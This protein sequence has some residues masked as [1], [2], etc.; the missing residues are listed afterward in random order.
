MHQILL[1]RRGGG[2]ASLDGASH[3]L[4]DM[5]I[6]NVPIGI[7]HGYRFDIGTEGDVVTLAA[8]MLDDSLRRSEGLRPVLSRPAVFDAPDAVLDTIAGITRTFASR[9]FGRAQILRSLSGLLLGQIAQTLADG[10][11]PETETRPALLTRFETLVEARFRDH[12]SVAGYAERLNVSPTHLSRICRAATG[13]PASRLIEERLIR[14]ARRN[15]VY[16]N[17]PVSTIA[18]E[19]GFD[20]PAYFSRV[21]ARATGLS[22]RAFRDS[23]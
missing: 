4:S 14:E 8:E 1:I 12:L 9:S 17:L 18:Y 5:K 7:V 22:P 15:L 11:D 16:T 13:R 10:Q 3:R 2:A 19:L 21:F 23:R 6:A 20:D